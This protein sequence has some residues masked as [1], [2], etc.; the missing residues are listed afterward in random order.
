M[1]DRIS[2]SERS[3]Q[4]G[5]KARRPLLETER[6]KRNVAALTKKKGQP[7]LTLLDQPKEST[8]KYVP[9]SKDKGIPIKAPEK[10][11]KDR[12]WYERHTETVPMHPGKG[13]DKSE[14]IGMVQ[15]SNVEDKSKIIRELQGYP[16]ETRFKA[17]DEGFSIEIPESTMFDRPRSELKRFDEYPQVIKQIGRT[18]YFVTESMFS[19]AKP[20]FQIAGK[21]EEF[22]VLTGYGIAVGQA[23]FNQK[24]MLSHAL[25]SKEKGTYGTHYPSLMDYVFE[26]IGWSPQGSTELL[27]DYPLESTI[28]GA[29][30]EFAQGVMFSHLVGLGAKGAGYATKGV[31][32]KTLTFAD[33]IPLLKKGTGI[34]GK[35][36]FGANLY[37]Y[38]TKGYVPVRSSSLIPGKT[39]EQIVTEDDIT[40]RIITQQMKTKSRLFGETREFVDPLSISTQSASEHLSISFP[41]M[42]DNSLEFTLQVKKSGYKR[43]LLGKS[44]S[45]SVETRYDRIDDIGIRLKTR[46][47]NPGF[48][49]VKPS[50]VDVSDVDVGLHAPMRTTMFDDINPG[51]LYKK[52]DMGEPLTSRMLLIDD[53]VPKGFSKY[54]ITEN[55][56]ETSVGGQRIIQYKSKML[57]VSQQLKLSDFGV[58]VSYDDVNVWA[59]MQRGFRQGKKQPWWKLGDRATASL[60]PMEKNIPIYGKGSVYGGEGLTHTGKSRFLKHIN[61]PSELP[62]IAPGVISMTAGKSIRGFSNK[63]KQESLLDISTELDVIQ[64]PKYN[65]GLITETIDR[66]GV[67]SILERD[68]ALLPLEKIVEKQQAKT[69][70]LLISRFDI[71]SVPI[72]HFPTTLHKSKIPSFIPKTTKK[73]KHSELNY[74]DVFS[75]FEGFRFRQHD[76]KLLNVMI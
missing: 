37:K 5:G 67:D 18:G 15:Q 68:V 44:F 24:K 52:I 21:G 57:P 13:Y 6:V 35:T 12:E 14:F 66:S 30:A 16:E 47:I 60:V 26:P 4:L 9:G 28:G 69:D 49:K 46:D 39:I 38:S 34:I 32:K 31:V 45:S 19:L 33:D 20:V 41:R 40:T 11:E 36:D 50:I 2:K 55:I 65:T 73:K 75:D 43:G 1:S 42:L 58:K 71:A 54:K 3:R 64:K 51:F 27:M 74:M 10:P 23:P 22:D 61:I 29:G 56:A 76:I 72:L 48:L 59:Q 70:T 53:S 7:S 63:S 25:E 8:S 17:T 62:L